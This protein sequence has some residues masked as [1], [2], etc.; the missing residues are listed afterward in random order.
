MTQASCIG[1]TLYNYMAYADDITLF[2]TNIQYLHNLIGVCVAYSNRWK[3]KFGVEKSKRTIV[4]KCSLY[5]EP[6]WRLGDTCL[7][8]EDSLNILGHVFILVV[9]MP[10]M[11]PQTN[12]MQTV[13]LLAW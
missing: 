13:I 11:S 6:K 2:S 9:I 12:K 5:Q 1:D 10:A 3:F 4:G 7:C 8:N